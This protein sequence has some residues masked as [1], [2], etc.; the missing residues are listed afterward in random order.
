MKT[1]GKVLIR[2]LI[3]GGVVFGVYSILPEYPHNMMKSLVQP[4]VNTEAKVRID[5]VKQLTNKKLNASYADILEP[6]SKS[7][8][9]VYE[10]DEV[11][12]KEMV[13]FYG[14][15][16]TLNI[17]DLPGEEDKLYTSC[18]VKFIFEI[19]GNSVQIT[20]EIDHKPQSEAVRD[21]MLRQIYTKKGQI[22]G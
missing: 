19:T 12:G 15:G 2:V 4:L 21:E 9:W 16:I 22:A 11:T 6:N 7:A 8:F 14:T 18:S 5:Q 3:L 13:L 17:K 10:S 20:G 1:L